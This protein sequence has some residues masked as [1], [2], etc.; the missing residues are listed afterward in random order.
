MEA[1]P[2]KYPKLAE[3]DDALC[4][5]R[6]GMSLD[7]WRSSADERIEDPD[8]RGRKR[9]LDE[10][11]RILVAAGEHRDAMVL[12]LRTTGAKARRQL[13]AAM[14]YA[15]QSWVMKALETFVQSCMFESTAP[16]TYASY[17]W[18]RRHTRAFVDMEIDESAAV[19]ARERTTKAVTE[20]LKGIGVLDG[21]YLIHARPEPEVFACL[22]AIE[23]QAEHRSECSV[24]WAAL[25]SKT[26]KFFCLESPYARVVAERAGH[27]AFF[28]SSYLAG[29]PRLVLDLSMQKKAA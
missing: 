22:L 15:E 10:A 3:L 8:P 19:S 18:E 9:I 4:A 12:I 25:E 20:A 23:L 27:G 29:T 17:V 28:Q 13:I 7:A 14:H 2:T 24:E 1:W 26:A 16:G 6:N 5:Y 21:E 11:Q